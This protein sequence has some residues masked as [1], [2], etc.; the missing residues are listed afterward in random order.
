TEAS[1]DAWIRLYRPYEHT[2]NQTVSYYLKGS[3][4]AMAL[5]LRMQ[6]AT[7]GERG[8]Q[9]VVQELWRQWSVEGIH[10]TLDSVLKIVRSC[11]DEHVAADLRRW[12]TTTE[13]PP[14][15]ALLAEQGV[16]WEEVRS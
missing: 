6:Q 15:R 5:D 12:V 7:D 10:Y 1:F 13:E 11:T 3:L 4:V 9:D 8:L 16:I 14:Y 2:R